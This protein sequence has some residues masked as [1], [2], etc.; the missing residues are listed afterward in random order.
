MNYSELAL[1]TLSPNYYPNSVDNFILQLHL[2]DAIR[3]SESLDL[4]KKSM[5]YGKPNNDHNVYTQVTDKSC[6]VSPDLIH[7][8]IGVLTEAG[9]L[10]QALLKSLEDGA[11][12]D[13]VNVGEE[14]GDVLWYIE[15]LAKATG[16]SRTQMEVANIKKLG[17]RYPNDE[18]NAFLADNRDLKIERESLEKDLTA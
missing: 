15:L 6:T 11:P 17:Q 2:E 13:L 16:V 7:G 1:K 9:E 18:F 3:A 4:C 8:I 10:A 5:F 12:I 14:C